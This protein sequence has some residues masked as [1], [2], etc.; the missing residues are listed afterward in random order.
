MYRT[1]NCG[2]VRAEQV[3]DEVT[4]AGWVN[5]HRDHGGITFLDLRDRSGIVQ[6]MVNPDLS[7]EVHEAV[8]VARDEVD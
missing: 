2:E 5:R 7:E 4:L 8:G 6:V 1:H 3:G